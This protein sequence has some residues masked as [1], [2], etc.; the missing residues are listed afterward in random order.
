MDWIGNS[1]SAYT[2]IGATNHSDG[3][4]QTDDYY[5]TEPATTEWLL[6]LENLNHIIWEPACGEGH[7]SKVLEQAGHT[8]VSS[9]LVY[10]GYGE[11]GSVDFLAFD[12]KVN[13]DI[14]TNPPYKYAQEFVEHALELV[15]DGCKVCMFLK[16]TFLEGKKRKKLF[17][18]YPPKVVYVSSS[19]LQC[20]KNG[21]FVKYKKGTGTAIAYG[22]FVWEKGYTGDTVV[23]WFN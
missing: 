4:R 15:T 12:H 20:A 17:E 2:C 6:K 3:E 22:W 14:V 11:P 7:M 18:K 9:D 8:V 13:L 16:L 1:K 19:R 21:D 10:R 5:A 23:K